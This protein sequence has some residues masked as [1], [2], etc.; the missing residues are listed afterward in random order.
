M[1]PSPRVLHDARASAVKSRTQAVNQIRSV[2]TADLV[3]TC[4]RLRPSTN[5]ARPATAARFALRRIARRCQEL[6]R[7]IS[8]Y[9]AELGVFAA[10]V[11]PGRPADHS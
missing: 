2:M 9:D 1:Q 7:E 11:A 4:A 8:E 6:D 3:V 10:L 5:L